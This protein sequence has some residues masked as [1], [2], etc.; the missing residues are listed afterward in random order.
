MHNLDAKKVLP[1]LKTVKAQFSTFKKETAAFPVPTNTKMSNALLKFKAS[2]QTLKGSTIQSS[3]SGQSR[4]SSLTKLSKNKLSFI[5]QKKES[6]LK[7][8]RNF[9]S[10]PAQKVSKEESKILKRESNLQT[11]RS[12]AL[13]NKLLKDRKLAS[14]PTSNSTKKNVHSL[15]SNKNADFFKRSRSKA[16]N[17]LKPETSASQSKNTTKRSTSFFKK[18]CERYKIS[19]HSDMECNEKLIKKSTSTKKNIL[20]S[21][22][23][24]K[25]KNL[26][27][28][29]LLFELKNSS[30]KNILKESLPNCK[31]NREST[32]QIQKSLTKNS[33]NDVF[34]TQIRALT[35]QLP[36]VPKASKSFNN[37]ET[38]SNQI[39][40]DI[41]LS[42]TR[43]EPRFK[44]EINFLS[45]NH[46]QIRWEMRAVVADWLQEVCCH[47]FFKRDTWH[48]AL[49]LVDRYLSKTQ[50]EDPKK[51]QLLGATALFI[52]A[53][54]DEVYTPK[55]EHILSSSC[56]IFNA[57]QILEAE[58]GMLKVLDFEVAPVTHAFWVQAFTTEWDSK[59]HIPILNPSVKFLNGCV[60]PKFKSPN[61]K[62]YKLFRKLTSVLDACLL[63]VESLKFSKRALVLAVMY[64]V[65][66]VESKQF[67]LFQVSTEFVKPSFNF[68]YQKS[69]NKYFL[70]FAEKLVDCPFSQM[71]SAIPFVAFVFDVSNDATFPLVTQAD[72]SVLEGSYE[73]FLAFQTYSSESLNFLIERKKK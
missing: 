70:S 20:N 10:E 15:S 68:D 38:V 64:L 14:K 54:L 71:I 22:S 27:K 42:L 57:T 65:I 4:N 60:P 11:S 47:Y 21:N 32:P 28:N 13:L 59:I 8:P 69:F 18:I 35:G 72:P 67:S 26:E 46:P 19:F 17:I 2:L 24:Q 66:G 41:L 7:D 31:S 53:K 49:N 29:S 37:H 73:E 34:K 3:T 6:T 5:I 51:L 63:D 1:D 58:T 40:D 45:K 30:K 50:N 36:S 9:S 43:I 52:A 55:I 25:T 39:S 33:S 12:S 62:S 61:E 23:K 44:L 56:R 48:I 16:E